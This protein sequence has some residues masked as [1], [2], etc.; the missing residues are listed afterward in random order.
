MYGPRDGLIPVG[1]K[2]QRKKVP[3]VKHVLIGLFLITCVGLLAGLGTGV[4][5]SPGTSPAQTPTDDPYPMPP[6]E[7][8]NYEGEYP[9]FVATAVGADLDSEQLVETVGPAVVSIVTETVSQGWFLQ[10]TP[11]RGAGT[12]AIISPD[13]HIVTNNHVVQGAQKVTVTLNDGRTFE[14]AG[15]ARDPQTDLAVVK[16][17]ASDL[18]YL[19]LLSNSLDQ[20]HELDEVVAVGNALALPGGPTWTAG[21]I[22]NLGRSI[23]LQDGVVLYDLIQTDA[24]INPGN[25]GGPLVNMA[26]Q[27]VG[28]N[29]AIA[30]EAENIGFAI[31][32]NTAI[33]VVKSLMEQGQVVRP[34]LGV[35]ILTVTPMIQYEFDLSV[36]E[37]ALIAEV[38]ADSAADEADLTPGDVIIRIG[39]QEVKTS[40]ALRSA[41]Q[42]HEPGDQ[43]SVTYVRG[44]AQKTTSVTLGTAPFS[45]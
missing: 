26:G 39:N 32:T 16:I 20:L 31:S 23:E 43:V 10:P 37:G 8:D 38:F 29:V 34:W 21:V 22:S 40:E 2:R 24:A 1:R 18:P 25:S 42:A 33:P 11:Q 28:I 27:L 36:S 4:F 30:A 5:D 41:I 45:F 6:G 14:A 19:H 12:G 15:V 13:G 3:G 17:D 7:V 35:S 44:S 9:P